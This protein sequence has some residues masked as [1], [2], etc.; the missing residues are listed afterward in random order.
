MIVYHIMKENKTEP[1]VLRQTNS[2]GIHLH[3]KLVYRP[4]LPLGWFAHDLVQGGILCMGIGTGSDMPQS[5]AGVLSQSTDGGKHWQILQ[6]CEPED[7]RMNA[8]SFSPFICT[9]K[10]TLILVFSNLSEKTPF[11]WDERI[12]DMPGAALPTYVM[13]SQDGG[14]TWENP[15]K[16]HNEWTGANRAIIQTKSGAVVFSSMKLLHNPGRHCVLTYRSEDEGQTWQASPHIDLGGVGHHGGVTESALVELK[17]GRLMQFLRTN[18]GQFW[19]AISEDDGRTFHP[20]GPTGIDASSAP[21]CL[22]RLSSGRIALLWNRWLPQG[23]Q[24]IELRGG[25]CNWSATPVSNFREELSLSF[26]DDEGISW[27]TPCVIARN[28]GGQVSYPCAFEAAP[29]EIWV[30]LHWTR[31]KNQNG[32]SDEAALRFSFMEKEFV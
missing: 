5:S 9:R 21:G 3:E 31:Y 32:C 14:Q 2:F 16:L 22:C 12:H 7:M 13:R 20:H 28:L 11:N 24:D 10:G 17:D 27:S 6:E 23:S 1:A 15:I 8:A 29:G 25:D 26:S 30:T 18:W 4:D 19:K